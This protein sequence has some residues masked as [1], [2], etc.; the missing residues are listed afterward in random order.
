MITGVALVNDAA[1]PIDVIGIVAHVPLS[2][3]TPVM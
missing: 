2:V 1:A 3:S